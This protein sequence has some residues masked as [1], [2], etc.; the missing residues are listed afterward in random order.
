MTENERAADYAAFI[1]GLPPEV[2]TDLITSEAVSTAF[3]QARSAGWTTE[4]L[5]GDAMF[6]MRGGRGVGNVVTRLRG[7][8]QARPVDRSAVA[9]VTRIHRRRWA[10]VEGEWCPCGEQPPHKVPKALTPEQTKERSDL[11][12]R[13]AAE[14]PHPDE[15][16][17]M[18]RE[19][20]VAQ[21]ERSAW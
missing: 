8:G 9:T 2:E 6:A 21:G 15:A 14:Q 4:Q 19:L 10:A 3:F 1:A 20:I 7:L 17:R 5:I 12:D 13:I 16:E 18:M 11:L